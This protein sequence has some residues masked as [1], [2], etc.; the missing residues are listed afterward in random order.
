M[1][2]ETVISPD[3]EE[4]DKLHP[5]NL[6][7]MKY[8]KIFCLLI[9]MIAGARAQDTD[10]ITRTIPLKI[11]N[12]KGRP[13]KNIFV[14]SIP[15]GNSGKTDRNGLFVFENMTDDDKISV[16]LPEYGVTFIPVEGLDSILVTLRSARLFTYMNNEG[17]NIA[18]EKGETT[19]NVLMDV[20]SFLQ[21][22]CSSCNSLYDLLQGRVAGLTFANNPSSNGS[23][24]GI[25]AS[26]RGVGSIRGSSEPLVVVDGRPFGTLNEA[27]AM[28]HVRDIKTIEVQKNGTEW[29]VQGANGVIVITTR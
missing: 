4:K 27:N 8:I 23:S 21:N 25:S 28:F 12:K 2:R 16:V 15:S 18:I 5:L 29:G 3:S 13:V 22:Q 17:Q 7:C 26:I 24:G 1:S 20:Q 9:F 14:Q 11:I 19:G 6:L 10:S